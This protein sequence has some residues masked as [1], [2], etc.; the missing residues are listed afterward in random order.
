MFRFVK[1]YRSRV[2]C[3][4]TGNKWI[5]IV[6]L[7]KLF[8]S[9]FTGH[10]IKKYFVQGETDAIALIEIVDSSINES[11]NDKSHEGELTDEF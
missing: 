4:D 8:Y 3:C 10:T 5:I 9:L 1:N 7:I 11:I 6:F 2:I